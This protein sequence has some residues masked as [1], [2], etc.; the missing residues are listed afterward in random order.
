MEDIRAYN[1]QWYA[2]NREKVIA[3]INAHQKDL[4]ARLRI[5][6]KEY[7]E[8]N[9]CVDC[10]ISYPSFVMDLDHVRGTKRNNVSALHK[11]GS[12][13][14]FWTEVAKCDLVCAN[15]HRFRTHK[16]T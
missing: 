12:E 5:L 13:A 14:Q 10:G 8:S 3:R 15:C 16:P 1:R 6:L 11:F 2:N 7:K 9:P 4:L